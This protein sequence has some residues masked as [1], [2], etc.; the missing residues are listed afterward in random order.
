[1]DLRPA[2]ASDADAIAR[3]HARS[4]RE[5][6][7]GVLSAAYLAERVMPEREALWHA[8][9]HSPRDGQHV[10]ALEDAGSLVAFCCVYVDDA[11]HGASYL[12]NLHVAASHRGQ[13]LGERLLRAA[14][15]VCAR[16]GRT[17]GLQL[18]VN[19]ANCEAQRFYL[20]LG[21]RNVA[22]AVW[23]APD[24]SA[25]PTFRFAWPTLAALVET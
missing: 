9:L 21:A 24:G 6:Y 25:V 1:M 13:G 22:S 8:R 7:A 5:A 16:D 12:D 10:L 19:Q 14:A 18:F 2:Q 3:L 17:P 15:R 4:W 23:H 20:R 11:A